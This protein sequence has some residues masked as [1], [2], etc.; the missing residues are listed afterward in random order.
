MA[1]TQWKDKNNVVTDIHDHRL[2]ASYG[3]AG[4]VIKVNSSASG[5]EYGSVQDTLVSGTN[6]KTINGNT[7]LGSGD[8]ETGGDVA[9][10]N[11]DDALTFTAGTNTAVEAN[12]SGSTSDTLS[13]I[14]IGDT[15]YA[16]GGG[17]S[18]L[19]QHTIN[20]KNNGNT[21]MC[22]FTLVNTSSAPLSTAELIRAE[23]VRQGFNLYTTKMLPCN[24][25]R[26]DNDAYRHLIA[27]WGQASDIGVLCLNQDGD[28][29]VAGTLTDFVTSYTDTV[30]QIS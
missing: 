6:I 28:T 8:L 18:M 26:T 29:K 11:S 23:L 7:L 21:C 30:T 2:P 3:T 13:S 27:V 17:S 15:S 24:G 5:F 12:P 25:F 16:V 20:C 4:Q 19:Y 1:T 10:F 22:V 9:E 14:K